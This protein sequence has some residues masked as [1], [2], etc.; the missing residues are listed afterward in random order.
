MGVRPITSKFIPDG[1][2]IPIPRDA[3]MFKR[4]AGWYLYYS[5]SRYQTFLIQRAR[6]GWNVYVYPGKA[7]PPCCG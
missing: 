6:G 2:S 7:V 5:P 1:Y 3:R 4:G